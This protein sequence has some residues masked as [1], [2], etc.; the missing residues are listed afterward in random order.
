M[1]YQGISSYE[2]PKKN[3]RQNEIMLRQYSALVSLGQLV[4]D[5]VHNLRMSLQR[6]SVFDVDLVNPDPITNGPVNSKS[7]IT[8]AWFEEASLT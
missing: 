1:A 2:D 5:E 4:Y 8:Q 6:N 3:T 7:S